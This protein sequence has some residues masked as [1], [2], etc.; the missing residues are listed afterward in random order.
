M[1]LPQARSFCFGI[2]VPGAQVPDPAN[3]YRLKLAVAALSLY[4]DKHFKHDSE[5]RLLSLEDVP[6]SNGNQEKV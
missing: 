2:A 3:E 4:L 1:T 6:N 5:G